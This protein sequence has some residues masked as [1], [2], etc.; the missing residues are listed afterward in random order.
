MMTLSPEAE[1]LVRR[2][3]FAFVDEGS[4]EHLRAL[5]DPKVTKIFLVSTGYGKPKKKNQKSGRSPAMRTPRARRAS[6]ATSRTRS[7]A[8][9]RRRKAAEGHSSRNG[10]EEGHKSARLPAVPRRYRR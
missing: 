8:E 6:T 2:H 5:N 1:R 7:M 3:R 10:G 4:P 9:I